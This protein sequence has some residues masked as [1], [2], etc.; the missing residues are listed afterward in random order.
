M[1]TDEKWWKRF[2]VTE[3]LQLKLIHRLLMASADRHLSPASSIFLSSLSNKT[4]IY[5]KTDIY[6]K[7]LFMYC[8]QELLNTFNSYV[9]SLQTKVHSGYQKYFMFCL[10]AKIQTISN[11]WNWQFRS[12]FFIHTV[13]KTRRWST[14]PGQEFVGRFPFL[15]ISFKMLYQSCW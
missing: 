13:G 8:L 5:K 6:S 12:T 1:K 3:Q 4:T 15:C 9:I 2:Y 14:R 10:G 11:A 7:W